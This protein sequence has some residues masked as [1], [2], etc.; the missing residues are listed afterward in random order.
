MYATENIVTVANSIDTVIILSVVYETC[1]G[2]TQVS[3]SILSENR[4]NQ[5]ST[6]L[7]HT[8]Y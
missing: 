4:L 8:T 1:D 6:F 3:I 5:C 7:S 2:E